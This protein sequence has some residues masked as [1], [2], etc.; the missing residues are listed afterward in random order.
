MHRTRDPTAGRPTTASSGHGHRC[1][2]A[3]E[4][5]MVDS[6]KMDRGW[7]TTRHKFDQ[8]ERRF[9]QV[10]PRS[11]GGRQLEVHV[12]DRVPSKIDAHTL[13]RRHEV[14]AAAR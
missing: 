6:T 5:S 3:R 8:M 11:G 4:T 13:R 12:T 7:N 9:Q 10:N 14:A 1:I 2:G